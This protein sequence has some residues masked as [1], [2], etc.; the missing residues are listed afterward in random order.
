MTGVA[1]NLSS[2]SVAGFPSGS[3]AAV[4]RSTNL[5]RVTIPP[6]KSWRRLGLRFH[7]GIALL[8]S[9]FSFWCIA[10]FKPDGLSWD[11]A[12]PN[13]LMY[14]SSLGIVLFLALQRLKRRTVIEVSP[15]HVRLGAFSPGGSGRWACWPRRDVID[16]KI[17]GSNGKLLIRVRE[18]DL[19]ERYLGPDDAFNSA[20]VAAVAEA[21]AELPVSDS[22]LPDPAEQT[23]PLDG[24]PARRLFWQT[25]GVAM[26]VGGVVLLFI[27]GP[28]G[29]IGCYIL[30]GSCIPFGILYGTQN[31]KF[32]L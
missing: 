30:I 10:G 3:G 22:T 8:A 11:I 21:L 7:I 17:N 6:V 14:G 16:I 19:V 15:T 13:A 5:V 20:A 28:V 31:K 2:P 27:P 9:M 29:V 24:S 18:S 1:P 32:W 23:L 25:V 12:L 26:I 4:E